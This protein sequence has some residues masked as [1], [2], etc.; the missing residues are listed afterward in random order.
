MARLQAGRFRPY[1]PFS[2]AMKLMIPTVETVKGTKKKTFSSPE[3]A[4]T[5]FGSFRTF[6][7]SEN[8][9]NGVVVVYDTATIDT[10]YRPDI[11]ADC[12]LYICQ[13]GETW[14]IIGDPENVALR[15]Q[16]MRI[17]VQKVGGNG[18]A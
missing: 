4:P 10:W 7:G 14:E 5:I 12:R 16:Y 8:T 17:R 3:D 13:T 18:T 1:A 6:G 11:K 9:E 15:N 2:V